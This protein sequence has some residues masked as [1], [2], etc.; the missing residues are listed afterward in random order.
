[1]VGQQNLG[2]FIG[3]RIPVRESFVSPF[4]TSL[5]GRRLLF[6]ALLCT[7]FAP[8]PLWAQSPSP[9]PPAVVTGFRVGERTET[10]LAPGVVWTQE[11]TPVGAVGGPLVVNAVRIARD[12][13]KNDRL[14]SALGY[15]FVWQN[16]ATQGRETVSGIAARM[17]AF[18]AINA[19]FFTYS[20]G[21]PLGISIENGAA[22]TE[23]LLGR[24]AF[25]WDG[26]GEA[27]VAA[28]T[29]SGAVTAPDGASFPV[30]GLNRK[31]GKSVELLLYTPRF[32]TATLPAPDRTE[33][34][35]TGVKS[36]R[37]GE[38][39]TGKV[40][41]VGTGGN[42]PLAANSVV[43]SGNGAAGE[44]LLNHAKSGAKLSV[45]YDVSPST[46][47][48][49]HAIAG[50]PRL[51][52]NS[53]PAIT[54]AAEG[55]G[56]AF[57]TARHP[58]SAAG[59]CADGAILLLSVDGRQP[60]L[61]RGATLAELAG[62]L[63]KFGAVRGVNFDGGGSTT[64]V[65]RGG[66]ANAPSDGVERPVAN[67]V[68]LVDPKKTVYQPPTLVMNP[69]FNGKI[70]VGETHSFQ[71]PY[72][73][74]RKQSGATWSVTG[75]IGFVSQ[76]G[77]F[78]ALRGGT[79][80]VIATLPGGDRFAFPVIVPKPPDAKPLPPEDPGMPKPVP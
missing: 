62:L 5:C 29:G 18:V 47:K 39:L 69:A 76:R 41:F 31:P 27:D 78:I 71:I 66:V 53:K 7:A 67:A 73:K 13:A 14:R 59:V 32:F 8:A 74:D 70:A 23:P 64:L 34:T 50:G 54:D 19:A 44:F 46:D 12:A 1:M 52:E 33:V 49:R 72:K 38:S 51:V 77:N 68:V 17:D 65:V 37:F 22:I 48:I 24:T 60:L 10:I 35:L 9:A 6:A 20:S 4:R 21:H 28:F 58:R 63:I 57:S 11:I 26:K 40:S 25:F 80:E 43:L 42:T 16:N 79:G 75:N 56:G 15:D 2:L 55:F 45:R 36:V 3:V 30:A 61:S